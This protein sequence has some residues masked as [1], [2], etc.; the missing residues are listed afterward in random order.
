[1]VMA[2][3]TS[4]EAVDCK[5]DGLLDEVFALPTSAA[6]R[7]FWCLEQIEPGNSGLNMPLAFRLDGELNVGELGRALNELIRRH[8]IL[9]TSFE[10]VDDRLNQVVS[11]ALTIDLPFEDLQRLPDE[12]REPH[13][14]RLINEEARLSFDLHRAPL[15]RARLIRM[16]DR[17]HVLLITMHHIVCDGWSNGVLVREIGALYE[18]FSRGLAS[19]LPDLRIQFADY[20]N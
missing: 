12:E 13:A 10:T 6:Q 11:P 7:R 2:E 4:D 8:E 9:R 18:A 16:T 14:N 1:M 15:F 20:A 3:P 5:G 19:P 17:V